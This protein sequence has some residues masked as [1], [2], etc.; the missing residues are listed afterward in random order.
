MEI[1]ELGTPEVMSR[2]DHSI[3]NESSLVEL[4]SALKALWS[5]IAT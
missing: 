3:R 1:D 5:N 2:A 4:Y